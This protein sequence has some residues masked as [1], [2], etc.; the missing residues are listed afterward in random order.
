MRSV[1]TKAYSID[2]PAIFKERSTPNIS[3]ALRREQTL[4]AAC[5]DNYG[6]PDDIEIRDVPIPTLATE[7]VLVRVHATTVNRT[8]CG[9]LSGSPW[10]FRLFVGLPHPRFS[11]LGTDFAGTIEAVGSRVSQWRI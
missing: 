4:K 10:V 11:V 3:A 6:T 1:I 9:V 2:M 5:R 8:D 7:D